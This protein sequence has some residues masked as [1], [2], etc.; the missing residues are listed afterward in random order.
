MKEIKIL[1]T[2]IQI[3]ENKFKLS[4][5]EMQELKRAL[6]EAL[7]ENPPVYIPYQP[8]YYVTDTWGTR[9]LTADEI[10]IYMS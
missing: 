3:G 7:P 9:E 6:L 10:P 4:V 1:K 2:E 5:D 8:P